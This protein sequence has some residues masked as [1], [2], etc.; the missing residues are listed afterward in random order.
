MTSPEMLR[1]VPLFSDLPDEYLEKLAR[2]A[3]KK[4]YPKDNVIFFEQDEGDSLFIIAR[5]S[6]KI[7][8]IS[9][10]GKEV[11]LAILGLGEFFGDMS[12]LD[13]LPRS[14]TVIA[15]E[16]TEVSSI[17]RKE[18]IS[19]INDNPLIAVKLL[20]VLSQRLRDANSKIGNLALLDVYGRLA[21]IL[22]D[23]A[24][25]EGRKL[26]NGKIAFRRPTH[27]AIA[28][29]IGTSRE[30]VTRTLGDLHRRGYIQISG[31]EI[32]I[33]DQFQRDFI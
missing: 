13:G 3:V 6:V 27:Q 24:K 33:K 19:L 31:K 28:N 10:E 29:M 18:F 26:E 32:I 17:R 15:V 30:T 1:R 9:D 12:L 22:M 5:G 20:S 4:T 16:E 7:A 25:I 21:R 23:F 2:V 11:I 8:K 14:A